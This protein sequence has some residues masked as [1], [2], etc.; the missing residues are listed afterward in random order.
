M[1]LQR[2]LKMAESGTPPLSSAG[3]K[4]LHPGGEGLSYRPE[5]EVVLGQP[6]KGDV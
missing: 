4:S 3:T 2:C 1:E 6:L 5:P